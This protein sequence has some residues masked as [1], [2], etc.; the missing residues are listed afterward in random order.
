MYL[1]FSP[2]TLKDILRLVEI[3]FYIL[4]NVHKKKQKTKEKNKVAYFI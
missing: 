4:R 1:L 3:R 2:I